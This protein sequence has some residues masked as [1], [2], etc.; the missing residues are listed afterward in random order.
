MA[1]VIFGIGGGVSSFTYQEVVPPPLKSS[2]SG[3][4]FSGLLYAEE[5]TEGRGWL[6]REKFD[7]RIGLL[8]YDGST[9]PP[10]VV[11]ITTRD[12]HWFFNLEVDGGKSL[13]TVFSDSTDIFIYVGSEFR[14]WY[15]NLE[16][17]AEVYKLFSF[18]V[19]LRFEPAKVK[20][21][22]FGADCSLRPMLLG[23]VDVNYSQ[24]TGYDPQTVLVTFGM[25]FKLEFSY[26]LFSDE[27]FKFLL[28]PYFETFDIGQG[29][30]VLVT[31]NGQQVMKNGGA[32]GISEPSSHTIEYGLN[33]AFEF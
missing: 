2:Q 5:T 18:P 10:N 31:S 24:S 15:R 23:S 21:G 8:D 14:V 29:A 33:A 1:E 16:N 20:T 28:S 4:L 25:G 6:A 19:G 17:P 32:L 22:S 12:L 11:A 30:V 3:A 26:Y 13:I 7:F 27:T 9:Q